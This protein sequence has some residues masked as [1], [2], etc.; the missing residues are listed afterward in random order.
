V[1]SNVQIANLALN[2]IGEEPITSFSDNDKAAR[3]VSLWYEPVRRAVLRSHPWNFAVAR[4]TLA[5]LT[6]VPPFGYAHKYALPSD[7]LRLLS[8]N[9][10]ARPYEI[11]KREF[12]TDASEVQLRYVYDVTDPNQYDTLFLMTFAAALA[13]KIAMPI[14]N[15]KEQA[16][17]ADAALEMALAEARSVD[18]ME[19]GPRQIEADEW[20]NAR[21]G[22]TREE[23]L[24]LVGVE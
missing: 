9:D 24:P 17:L 16:K 10:A 20:L 21:F 12:L 5:Q 11:E 14:T 18:A 2:V 23:L 1:A 3:T 22:A 8:V 13:V 6:E 4:R 7:F 15:D 19:I